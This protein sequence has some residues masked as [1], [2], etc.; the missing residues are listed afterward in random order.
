MYFPAPTPHPLLLHPMVAYSYYKPPAPKTEA[1]LI[2]YEV[3]NVTIIP[4]L[5]AQ[6]ARTLPVFHDCFRHC[7]PM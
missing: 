1:E 3:Q 2:T 6:A 4:I 5:V 7:R